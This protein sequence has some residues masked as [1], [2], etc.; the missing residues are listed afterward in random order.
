MSVPRNSWGDPIKSSSTSGEPVWGDAE[1]T[2]GAEGGRAGTRDDGPLVKGQLT[3]R[4]GQYE[5][6]P[7]DKD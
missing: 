6:R 3:R 5:V 7:I 4:E 1:A 2:P